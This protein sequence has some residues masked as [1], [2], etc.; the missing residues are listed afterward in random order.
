MINDLPEEKKALSLK[1][2]CDN[3]FTS[4]KLLVHFR[5]LGYSGTCIIRDNRVPKN[6]SLH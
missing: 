2:Y 4:P 5:K 1:F 3:L 6:C